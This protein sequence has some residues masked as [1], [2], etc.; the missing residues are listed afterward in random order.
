MSPLPPSL[1]DLLE[2]LFWNLSDFISAAAEQTGGGARPAASSCRFGSDSGLVFFAG[3]VKNLQTWTPLLQSLLS[4][5]GREF[6]PLKA[7]MSASPLSQG[8]KHLTMQ[9]RQITMRS[10]W[11]TLFSCQLKSRN[12]PVI[13]P[14]SHF[15]GRGEWCAPFPDLPEKTLICMFCWILRTT[16]RKMEAKVI[17]KPPLASVLLTTILY[18]SAQNDKH[19]CVGKTQSL[20]TFH[21]YFYMVWAI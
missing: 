17:V 5:K 18:W 21:N 4:P 9:T 6:I 15:C 14:Q 3:T 16:P 10:H 11:Q 7:K 20:L 13:F 19:K 2:E 8:T 12:Y 1:R